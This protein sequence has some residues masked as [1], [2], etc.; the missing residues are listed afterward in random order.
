MRKKC[1]QGGVKLWV[2]L[3]LFIALVWAGFRVGRTYFDQ[4][5]IKNEVIALADQSLLRREPYLQG[6]IVRLLTQF[7]V[8]VKEE[9]IYIGYGP[10]NNWITVSFAYRKPVDLIVV[11][12]SIPFELDVRRESKKASSI[13]QGFQD[14]VESANRAAAQKYQRAIKN[15]TGGK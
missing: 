3:I 9:N 7:D 12:P 8:F 6:K 13:V 4:E 14:R 5:T 1:D 2:I 10:R 15:A 11:K